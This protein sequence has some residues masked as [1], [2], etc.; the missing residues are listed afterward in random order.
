MEHN[1]Y[2]RALRRRWWVPVLAALAALVATLVSTSSD[3]ERDRA[4]RRFSAAHVVSLLP[5]LNSQKDARAAV[6]SGAVRLFRSP[7]V[8]SRAAAELDVEGD[9]ED[10][11]A[12]VDV[13]LEKR[14]GTITFATTGRDRDRVALVANVFAQEALALQLELEEAAYEGDLERT[15]ERVESLKTRLNALDAQLGG[16]ATPNAAVRAT[17]DALATQLTAAVGHQADLET[18]GPPA[19]R[20]TTV[21]EAKGAPVVS[22]AGEGFGPPESRRGRFALALVL[23]LVLAVAV[24]VVLDRFDMRLVD[25]ATAERAFGL[26]VLTEVPQLARDGSRAAVEMATM[27]LSPVAEA[28]RRLRSAILLPPPVP[29]LPE[30]QIVL[31]TS[32]GA[33]QGRTTTVANLAASFAEAGRSVLVIDCDLRRPAL[34][35][36]LD[37]GWGLGLTDVLVDGGRTYGLTDVARPT[38]VPGVRLVPS[39][40]PQ[41]NPA[42]LL[43]G[44]RET[45]QRSR[46]EAD[47]VIVDTAAALEF[48]DAAELAP[49][50]DAVLVV[51]RAGETGADEARRM[52][53]LLARLG[54]P[55]LGV[56][57]TARPAGWRLRLPP[58]FGRR[59]GGAPPEGF[60]PGPGIG[61]APDGGSPA[62]SMPDPEPTQAGATLAAVPPEASPGPATTMP[63]LEPGSRLHGRRTGLLG[64]RL[65][66]SRSLRRA[67]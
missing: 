63:V 39:G 54:T 48:N 29:G 28:F 15:S 66:R 19:D 61:G 6:L 11:A 25:K 37:V 17:R 31:V 47:V 36:L 60:D 46:A 38:S 59:R 57:L 18:R 45:L 12:R 27:P 24:V 1:E 67:P 4:N 3:A 9:G 49:A 41:P 30:I 53:E 43:T 14:R 62:P 42:V 55:V 33:G 65:R 52:A 50:A 2:L 35:Q 13:T 16:A 40:T 7:D 32:P 64:D 58:R 5:E 44:A 23:A 10:L 26:P 8:A 56:V 51:A 22:A 21:R 20:F 34:D